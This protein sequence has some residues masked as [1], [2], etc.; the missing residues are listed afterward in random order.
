MGK[1]QCVYTDVVFHAKRDRVTIANAHLQTQ[2]HKLMLQ[3]VKEPNF[4]RHTK[5]HGLK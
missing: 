2:P 3:F 4:C 1:M 5:Q